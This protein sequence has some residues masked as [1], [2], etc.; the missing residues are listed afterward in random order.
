MKETSHTGKGISFLVQGS[1]GVGK[2]ALIEELKKIA[3]VEKWRVCD[4]SIECLWDNDVFYEWL[5]KNNSYGSWNAWLGL[6]FLFL[7]QELKETQK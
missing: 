7:R 5:S 3:I 4:I 1:P 2:T 6:D